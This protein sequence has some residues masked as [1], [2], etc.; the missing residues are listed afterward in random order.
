MACSIP[1]YHIQPAIRFRRTIVDFAFRL[2][3]FET[4]LRRLNTARFE[5]RSFRGSPFWRR[6]A[7]VIM[8]QDFERLPRWH[9]P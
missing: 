3:Y 4:D 7:S 8:H 5:C 9:A 2:L 6:A 1:V